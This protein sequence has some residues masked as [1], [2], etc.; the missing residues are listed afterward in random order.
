MDVKQV[1]QDDED[2]VKDDEEVVEE[3]FEEKGIPDL[4]SSGSDSGISMASV[5]TY[6]IL[7][8]VVACVIFMFG[9][10]VKE[11]FQGSQHISSGRVGEDVPKGNICQRNLENK[12]TELKQLLS[13]RSTAVNKKKVEMQQ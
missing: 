3:R 11:Y 6:T 7:G 1:L 9:W 12:T 4:P 5:A 10:T 2:V 8:I 13:D